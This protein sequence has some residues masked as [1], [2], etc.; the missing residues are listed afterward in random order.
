[1][2]W[3]TARLE[4]GP[5]LLPRPRP[6]GVSALCGSSGGREA[7]VLAEAVPTLTA[8]AR[9]LS[10]L[11][12]Q[13]SDQ[14]RT[15]AEGSAG[16]RHV[17]AFPGRGLAGGEWESSG[18]G[19]PHGRGGRGVRAFSPEEASMTR[20]PGAG[21]L[22]SLPWTTRPAQPLPWSELPRLH[23]T[24]SPEACSFLLPLDHPISDSG[25]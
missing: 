1:M 13:A 24:C 3:W 6:G 19:V 12:S 16:S 18:L 25:F 7:A 14:T 10:C 23:W 11:T 15:S 5:K 22:A 2:L 20:P 4:R 17:E 9:R 8:L 21:A